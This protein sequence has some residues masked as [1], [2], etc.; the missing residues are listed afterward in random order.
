MTPRRPPVSALTGRPSFLRRCTDRH[1]ASRAASCQSRPSRAPTSDRQR[2]PVRDRARP[3]KAIETM[4]KNLS[5][6]IPR[7]H[8]G[9]MP[10]DMGPGDD[11]QQPD[12]RRSHPAGR[13][14]SYNSGWAAWHQRARP[15]DARA[16]DCIRRIVW[17]E[18]TRGQSDR[19]PVGLARRLQRRAKCA[20]GERDGRRR[21]GATHLD[22]FRGRPDGRDGTAIESPQEISG[23]ERSNLGRRRRGRRPT[24]SSG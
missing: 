5:E 18:V 7:F 1:S 20:D 4:L 3:G 13:V 12:L 8:I 14:R 17:E 9:V 15:R 11:D 2:V 19:R 22:V 6:E 10:R 24:S 16:A 23:L 21:R